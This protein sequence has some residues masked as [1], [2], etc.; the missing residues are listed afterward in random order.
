ML[1][2]TDRPYP[3]PTPAAPPDLLGLPRLMTAAFLGGDMTG[4]AAALIARA[5]ADPG[6]AHA[7]MDLA[8]VL[9]LQGQREIGLSLQA[10]ALALRRHYRQPAVR[11]VTLRLL[12][13]M[14]DGDLMANAP[15]AF[16][17]EDSEVALDMVY[18]RPGEPLPTPDQLPP[19]DLLCVAISESDAR[20]PLLQ[21]LD[22]A[23]AEWPQPVLNRPAQI[24]ATAREAVCQALHGVP[25]VTMPPSARVTRSA[26]AAVAAGQQALATAV[27][28][29]AFPVIVRPVDS[30]AGHGLARLGHVA[31][32]ARYLID[33]PEADF[34]TSPFIDYRS[35]DGQYR[36]YRVVIVGERA[37]GGHMAIS[38]HWMVHYLNAGM[39]DSAAK[40]AEEAIFLQHFERDFA[41]RHR[42]ALAAIGLHIGL[43]YLVI[44]CAE[45]PDGRLLVF[46][47]DPGAVVHA[48]DPVEMFPYKQV[49]MQRL[50]AAYRAL[51]HD[52]A[53]PRVAA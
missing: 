15:L 52:R 13:L 14:T 17:V 6:D 40:R 22:A 18:L 43:D 23:L 1:T 41:M 3:I 37:M 29:Q 26:L 42:A 7:L 36:K 45:T 12:A 28:G 44:D 27:P 5:D 2:T 33:Q 38:S 46:E 4:V 48:M 9:M 32:L 21:A 11:P 25:G 47:V 24:I 31:D 16:L 30:H 50:F 34:I 35:A 19:H 39:T 8:T 51:L 53:A 49:P 20:R 10:E